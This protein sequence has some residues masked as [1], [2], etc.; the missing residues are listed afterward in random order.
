[1]QSDSKQSA[2]GFGAHFRFYR[3]RAIDEIT[4]P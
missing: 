1:L 2:A 4:S 3:Q